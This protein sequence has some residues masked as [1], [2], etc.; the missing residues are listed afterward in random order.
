M[1]QNVKGQLQCTGKDWTAHVVPDHPGQVLTDIANC[2]LPAVTWVNPKGTFSDHAG[3]NN[4]TGPQWVA[5]IVNAIGSQSC[6]GKNYWQDT[7]IFITWDDW[8]G[9][10]DHVTPFQITKPISWGAGYTYGFRVPLLVVS[11]FTP[12][13]YVNNDILDF[14]SILYFVE[15]NF[16]LGFIGPG[17]DVYTKY[18]DYQAAGGG[19]GNLSSFFTLTSPKSFTPIK[20]N[21]TAQEFISPPASDDPPDND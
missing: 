2:A 9:W 1:A 20:T 14:G 16:G 13:S 5:S 4:G 3:F 17:T 7:A 15:Q 6:N 10:F 12:T 11:A 21:K 18:A 8:G 19:R